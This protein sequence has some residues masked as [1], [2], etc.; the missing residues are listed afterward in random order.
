MRHPDGSDTLGV[1]AKLIRRKKPVGGSQ[2]ALDLSTFLG[3]G[4]DLGWNK[5]QYV[6]CAI[7]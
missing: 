7:D 1:A 2:F 3:V 5:V 4:R 6:L